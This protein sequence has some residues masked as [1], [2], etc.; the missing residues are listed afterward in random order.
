MTIISNSTSAFYERSSANMAAQRKEAEALQAQLG[1]KQRL[2][3]SSD[4]PVVASRLRTLARADTMAEI[5]LTAANRA[6]SDL[7]LTDAALESVGSYINRA[8]EIAIM[9]ANGTVN[10]TQRAAFGVELKQMLGNLVA[11]GNTRDSA[12]KSLFGGSLAG[13][14][15][16]LDGSGNPVYAGNG[17]AIEIELGQGQTVKRGLTGPE[18]LNFDVNGTPTDLMTVIK[19]LGDALTT[20][21]NTQQAS[22]DGMD[23]L[24]AGLDKLTTNQTIVGSRLAWIDMTIDQRTNLGELRAEEQIDIGQ[25]DLAATMAKLTQAMTVLEFSQ[26]SFTKLSQLSLFDNIR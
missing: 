4:N 15:Y 10:D 3:K 16:S 2:T 20:G 12:G 1:S 11:L 6:A 21:T 18:F 13:N 22:R 14:P 19:N 17:S 7:Q 23:A 8:K 24:D 9:A 26:A 5:D 25:V